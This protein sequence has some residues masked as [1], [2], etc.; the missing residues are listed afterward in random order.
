MTTAPFLSRYSTEPD[1]IGNIQWDA[2]T[3]HL[4]FTPG[5]HLNENYWEEPEEFNADRFISIDEQQ[6]QQ[7]GKNNL[8]MWGR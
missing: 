5:I 2:D 8:I 4:I 6:Q 3:H 7:S 1:V